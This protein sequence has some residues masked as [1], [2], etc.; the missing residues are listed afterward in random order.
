MASP[1][2]LSRNTVTLDRESCMDLDRALDLEWLEVDGCGGFASSTPVFCPTR[3]YHGLL[4]TTPEGSAKRHV[5]LSRFDETLRIGTEEF[6]ISIARYG[7]TYAP[8]GHRA[9]ERFEQKPYPSVTYRIG[10]A[11]VEREFLLVRGTPIA[12]S[13]YT[14]RGTDTPIELEL[15]PLM[16]CREADALT[17]KNDVLDPAVKVAGATATVQPYAALPA[18]ALSWTGAEATWH[19]DSVWYLGLEY[20]EDAARGYDSSEDQWSPGVLRVRLG[21]GDS[22]LVAASLEEPVPNAA[23][24]WDVEVDVRQEPFATE[25][26]LQDRL[27]LA[28]EDFLY[29]DSTGRRGVIAGYPWFGEWGRDTFIALPG[30]TLSR[31]DLEGCGEVLSG[32]LTYLHKGLLPNVFGVEPG[33]SHYGSVD[34]ALW[35][36]RA[37]RLYQRAGGDQA[38]ILDE[39]YPALRSMANAYFE[40]SELEIDVDAGGLLNAGSLELNPTWM[41]ARTE[42]G[43]VTPRHGCAVEI[44]A[45]WYSM[46]QVL[47][48][49]S[50]T[51]GEREDKKRWTAARRLAKKTFLER[52]W[53][54]DERYL[55][56]VWRE[57]ELDTSVRPNMVLAAALEYS[58]LTKD[59]RAGVVTR[60]KAELVTPVG[61][62]TLAP[63]DPDYLG[64]YGGDTE[65]RDHAYHQG[66]VWPWLMGFFI[67]A[68]L[69]AF[70]T[71]RVQRDELR[72]TYLDS[73]AIELGRHG[74]G[75]I[76]EVY[77]GDPPHEP[78]GTIAQAWSVSELLRAHVLLRSSRL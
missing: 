32:A 60:A 77:D 12:L 50:S 54:E 29:H 38:R 56:D 69:R 59:K 25:L 62:R 52:F 1:T 34:A 22:I 39:Y 21:D 20:E 53:L 78:G 13:R 18:V 42:D 7:D 26:D 27:A 11:E 23:D 8:M 65:S 71:K 33:S 24:L 10:G 36:A 46:L 6:P 72:E 49:L 2:T 48:E 28:A 45:L 44:N 9:A 41:D 67:E 17:V 5:F 74:L 76:S 73:F 68:H 51:K 3:R 43:P 55:A 64:V 16:P 70:G 15:R 37:V 19:T 35:F 14:V 30:L 31:G 57:D 4:V 61:L 40:G 75:Q 66:T 47:E 63:A 58:P